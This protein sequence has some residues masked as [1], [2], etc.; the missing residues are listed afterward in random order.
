MFGGLDQTPIIIRFELRLL[1][2]ALL[3]SAVMPNTITPALGPGI[4]SHPAI[5]L[6]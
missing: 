6:V 1:A 2:T 5:T 3:L 4:P